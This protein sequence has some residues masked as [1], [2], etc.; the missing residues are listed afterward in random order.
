LPG[1]LATLIQPP[2]RA[3]WCAQLYAND[4]VVYAKRPFGGPAQVLKY[5]ARYTHRVAISNSRLLELRDGRLTFPYKDYADDHKSKTMTLTAHEFLR[6]FLQHSF[7]QE[8]RK[9]SSLRVVGERPTRRSAGVVP[10]LVA[11]RH[12]GRGT[13]R[14]RA[15]SATVLWELRRYA[16]DLSGAE[17]RGIGVGQP[18]TN[19]GYFVNGAWRA[20]LD[21]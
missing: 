21:R 2:V 19:T 1:E 7:A 3:A 9:D 10:T 16:F 17:R 5:L 11:G 18:S 8:L 4:W 13:T 14:C 6:R 20:C 15:R 12:G